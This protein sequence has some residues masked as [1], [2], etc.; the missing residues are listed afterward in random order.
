MRIEPRAVTL[1]EPVTLQ[2]FQALADGR[3]RQADA[4][5]QFDIGDPPVGLQDIEDF[6][7]NFVNFAHLSIIL[8]LNPDFVR[9]NRQ[10]VYRATAAIGG[11]IWQ[12]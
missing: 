1:D 12:P 3:R 7:V 5:R 8:C 10:F 2:P 11:S 4:L 6:P 9:Q